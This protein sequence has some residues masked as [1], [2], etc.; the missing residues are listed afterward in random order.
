M[1][2]SLLVILASVV[3]SGEAHRIHVSWAQFFQTLY[4]SKQCS[5]LPSYHPIVS[6][7]RILK[8]NIGAT[9]TKVCPPDR[10]SP[11]QQR[12]SASRCVPRPQR[13]CDAGVYS[14]RPP[15]TE[16]AAATT[17]REGWGWRVTVEGS[18]SFH[19]R[20]NISSYR[21][22]SFSQPCVHLT[23][24]LTLVRYTD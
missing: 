3:V 17:E 14:Q 16:A 18:Q 19:V 7:K 2:C 1:R 8:S 15:R 10:R 13:P 9:F 22:I 21:L 11:Q 5:I 6:M 23:I 20:I 12:R 24:T 4:L